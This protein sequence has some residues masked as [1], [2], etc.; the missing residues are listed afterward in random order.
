MDGGVVGYIMLQLDSGILY[1]H[2]KESISMNWVEELQGLLLNVKI[3]EQNG[4]NGDTIIYVKK[5]V[6]VCESEHI[7]LYLHKKTLEKHTKVVTSGEQVA[8]Q[9]WIGMRWDEGFSVHS[10]DI[11][12]ILDLTEKIMVS[13]LDVL[14]SILALLLNTSG[15]F[16]QLF[17]FFLLF[18]IIPICEM[19]IITVINS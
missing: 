19:G 4:V 18:N 2:E 10:F 17:N 12:D 5:C 1:S 6:C 7:F 11:V 9:Q 16:G 14:C 15:N 13:G 3:K 8:G